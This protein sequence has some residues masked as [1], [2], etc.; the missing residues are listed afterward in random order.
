MKI[1]ENVLA[2]LRTPAAS[3]EALRTKLLE[4][5]RL[6]P[7]AEAEA[8]RLAVERA[9]LLLSASDREIEA[10]ER[11]EADARRAVDRLRA[12]QEE[13]ARRLDEA[14]RAEARAALD[15]DRVDAERLAAETAA[16]VTKEYPAAARK[17]AALVDDLARAE[18]AVAAVNSRLVDAGRGDEVLPEVEQRALPAPDGLYDVPHRLR[19]SVSLP[20]CNG[21]DGAGR[22]R[23][24]ALVAGMIG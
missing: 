4:V 17:I 12:A 24:A 7:E 19:N 10:V 5:E 1:I 16:R 6:I 23:E 13:L 22:A 14:E 20:P 2:F 3:S 18:A 8:S 9:G 21:F 15:A 11:R